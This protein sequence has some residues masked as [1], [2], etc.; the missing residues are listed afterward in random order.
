MKCTIDLYMTETSSTPVPGR[1]KLVANIISDVFSPLLVP[2]YV[3]VASMWLTPLCLLPV[4]SRLSASAGIAFITA[5]IPLVFIFTMIRVGRISDVSISD[6]RQRKTPYIVALICYIAAAVFL[7]S[8]HAPLWLVVFYAAGAVVLLFNLF[9]TAKTK[10]SAH[11]SA[12]GGG[13][14]LIFWL[15][16]R[17]YLIFSPIVWVSVAFLLVG[18]MAWARLYLYRHTLGQVVAGAFLSFGI[19]M[20]ALCLL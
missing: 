10:I 5:V 12:I 3:M 18:A 15:A 16:M 1:Y 2:T 7:A 19:E 14:A 6:A 11:T 17:G 8:L 9:I 20:T 4:G 13:C